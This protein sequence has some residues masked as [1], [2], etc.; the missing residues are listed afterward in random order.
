M[1]FWSDVLLIDVMMILCFIMG[2][3]VIELTKELTGITTI[4]TYG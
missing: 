3:L 4:Y 2:G 1:E